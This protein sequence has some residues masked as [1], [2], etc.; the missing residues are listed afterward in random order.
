MW[1]SPQLAQHSMW[2]ALRKRDCVQRQFK[3]YYPKYDSF[4]LLELALDWLAGSTNVS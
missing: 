2:H 3:I 4:R 1:L